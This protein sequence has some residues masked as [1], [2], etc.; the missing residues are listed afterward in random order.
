ME[1]LDRIDFKILAYL[2]EHGRVTNIGLADAVGLSASPCL[3]RVKRL[4][5]IGYIKSYGARIALEKLGD[6]VTVF[7]EVTL[8]CHRKFNFD[9]FLQCARNV[10]EIIECH[11]VT[12]GYDYL[13]KVVA[14]SVSR[15]QQAMENCW[16]AT[17][18]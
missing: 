17:R 9:R 1:K 10:P 11:H 7:T 8:T 3:F 13:L 2:Q 12:G 14:R 4:E 16:I 18:G 5:K 6:Y 15:Y